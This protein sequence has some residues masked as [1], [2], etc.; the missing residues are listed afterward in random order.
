MTL[1]LDG[2]PRCRLPAKIDRVA[3]G[4]KRFIRRL[5]AL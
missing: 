1:D 3:F 4:R 5:R 2:T